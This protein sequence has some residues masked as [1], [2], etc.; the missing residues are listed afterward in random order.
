MFLAPVS[1]QGGMVV[2]RI[3]SND[4][5][6]G[7]PICSEIW[8]GNTTDA[9]TLLPVIERMRAKFRVRELCVVG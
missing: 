9:K 7:R 3:V 1:M 5:V 2:F 6:E 4:D 8:P